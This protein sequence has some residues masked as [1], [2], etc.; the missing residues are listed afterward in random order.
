MTD[1]NT[2]VS[3]LNQQSYSTPDHQSDRISSHCFS[4]D[5][6]RIRTKSSGSSSTTV[7]S[8]LL[9]RYEK[10]L[11]ERQQAMVIANEELLDVDDDD[12]LKRY[13]GKTQNLLTTR[14]NRVNE[15]FFLLTIC[16]VLWIEK[17]T[18]MKHFSLST[19]SGL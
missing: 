3:S 8:S 19:L 16:Y 2:F 14:S 4:N 17:K 11:R 9:E 18:R 5:T 7:L 10:T 13:R 6:P 15:I 12:V 1:Y